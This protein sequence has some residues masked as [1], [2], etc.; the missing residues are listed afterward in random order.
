MGDPAGIGPEICARALS[1]EQTYTQCRPIIVG[2]AKIMQLA[3][4]LLHLPLRVNAVSDVKDACF[5]HGTVDV[6]DLDIIDLSTFR[7]GE[8][9]RQCG[10]AAFRY[11]R[12]AIDLAMAKKVDGTCTAPLNKEAIHLAGHNY[13]GHTEIYATF[14][15]YLQT[16]FCASFMSQHTSRCARPATAARKSVS[17]RCMN[18]STT[19]AGSSA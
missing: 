18:S 11:V 5:T 4:D 16:D 12:C 7:F 1:H 17:S 8:V 14:T 15:G 9:Q 2:D 19:P 3:V 10:D 6:F 13:D